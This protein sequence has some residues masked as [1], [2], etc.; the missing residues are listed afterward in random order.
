MLKGLLEYIANQLDLFKQGH[1]DD[2]LLPNLVTSQLYLGGIHRDTNMKDTCDPGLELPQLSYEVCKVLLVLSL[3]VVKQLGVES[4]DQEEQ[5]APLNMGRVASL[6]YN[7]WVAKASL[8]GLC[9]VEILFIDLGK[10][11][12]GVEDVEES[13]FA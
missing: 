13:N 9:Q 11:V 6:L 2:A 7:T 3:R 8:G 1:R 10:D 12:G 5:L 4:S